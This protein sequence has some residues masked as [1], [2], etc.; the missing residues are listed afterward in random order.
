MSDILETAVLALGEKIGD[1]G[2]DGIAKFVIK[3][4]G[5]II[6]DSDGARV[7]DGD[8]DV[9]LTAEAETFRGILE[10]GLSPAT[11]FMQGKLAVDGDMSVALKLGSAI[12]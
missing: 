8:A 4:E 10:G 1:G 11:A 7:D 9:T 5:A 3:G 12:A 6:V 2:F